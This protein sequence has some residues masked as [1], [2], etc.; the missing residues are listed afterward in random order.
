MVVVLYFKTALIIY[1]YS[2]A[3][4]KP[5]LLLFYYLLKVSNIDVSSILLE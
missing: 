4:L 1:I 5:H 2:T 3:T